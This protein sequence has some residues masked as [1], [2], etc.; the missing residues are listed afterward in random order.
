MVGVTAHGRWQRHMQPEETTALGRDGRGAARQA[1]P[2]STACRVAPA[3]GGGT[4]GNDGRQ[5]RTSAVGKSD[6][7]QKAAAWQER[8]QSAAATEDGQAHATGGSMAETT[9]GKRRRKRRRNARTNA[10]CSPGPER[11]RLGT[12]TRKQ[13]SRGANPAASKLH[14]A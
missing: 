13:K 12:D 7:R 14:Q 9:A 11:Q 3:D 8:R 6:G 2:E 5:G 1:T 4:D 10:T